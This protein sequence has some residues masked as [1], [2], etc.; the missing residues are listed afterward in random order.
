MTNFR[1]SLSWRDTVKYAV[2]VYSFVIKGKGEMSGRKF[3]EQI[4]NYCGCS[5][6]KMEVILSDVEKHIVTINSTY[7][8]TRYITI[9][10]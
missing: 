4:R 9:Q 8:V 10:S 7:T 6:E 2:D 5:D 1:N 3:A